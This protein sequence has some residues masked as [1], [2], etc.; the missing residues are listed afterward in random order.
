MTITLGLDPKIQMLIEKQKTF[1]R[2][3]PKG[4]LSI[5]Q[6]LEDL[7]MSRRTKLNDIKN[8]GYE[9]SKLEKNLTEIKNKVAGQQLV[10][11]LTN[12]IIDMENKLQSLKNKQIELEENVSKIEKN[13]EVK[14][15]ISYFK[16][17]YEDTKKI[18]NT[19]L[20]WT[21]FSLVNSACTT[22]ILSDI[23]T[24]NSLDSRDEVSYTLVKQRYNFL[25]E[26]FIEIVAPENP[27]TTDLENE[28]FQRILQVEENLAHYVLEAAKLTLLEKEQ[29][30]F[31]DKN[32][33][34][35][36]TQEILKASEIVETNQG[37]KAFFV[38]EELLYTFNMGDAYKYL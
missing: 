14:E 7:L 2:L 11:E 22:S 26:K 32:A 19:F 38:K 27:P 25:K 20:K 8:L 36:I 12:H 21:E 35:T 17:V 15:A 10:P 6:R 3:T 9:I 13:E 5:N 28:F 34:N 18:N 30:N 24:K 29:G 1:S 31:P 4:D 37:K 23:I 16:K 33:I